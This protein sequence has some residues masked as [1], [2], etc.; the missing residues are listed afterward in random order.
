MGCNVCG[1]ISCKLCGVERSTVRAKSSFS[2]AMPADITSSYRWPAEGRWRNERP[3]CPGDMNQERLFSGARVEGSRPSGAPRANTQNEVQAQPGAPGARRPPEASVLASG[4]SPS[5]PDPWGLAPP[6]QVKVVNER[7]VSPLDKPYESKAPPKPTHEV[8]VLLDVH[9][10]PM[11]KDAVVTFEIDA[12]GHWFGSEDEWH[13]FVHASGDVPLPKI[14][15]TTW[16]GFCG[17]QKIDRVAAGMRK[18]APNRVDVYVV[19][20]RIRDKYMRTW[21]GTGRSLA[22]VRKDEER[23]TFAVA[24]GEPRT[25]EELVMDGGGGAGSLLDENGDIVAEECGK[26]AKWC[27]SLERTAIC[28]E[29]GQQ[30]VLEGLDPKTIRP[31]IELEG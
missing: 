19:A 28:D 30:K 12:D 27:L 11:H 29:C 5:E 22:E 17:V 23:W 3:A 15:M 13:V 20:R 10:R 1:V 21:R 26:P 9:G 8:I 7:P 2:S 24:G 25:C 14:A 16:S 18:I 6:V 31:V 4:F